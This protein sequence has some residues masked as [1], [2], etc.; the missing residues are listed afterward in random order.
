MLRWRKSEQ[1][2]SYPETFYV[3]NSQALLAILGATAV[4]N[5]FYED[6]CG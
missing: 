4:P 5:R 3:V 2:K 1:G 6:F